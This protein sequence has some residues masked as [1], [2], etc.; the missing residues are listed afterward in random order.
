MVTDPDD[1]VRY[2]VLHTLCDGS[3]LHLITIG[4]SNA[5]KIN[6]WQVIEKTGKWNIL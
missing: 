6:L 2:Q 5:K 3:Q 4:Q 1:K